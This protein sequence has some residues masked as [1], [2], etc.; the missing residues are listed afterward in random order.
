[1]KKHT[2]RILIICAVIVT[3]LIV[4]AAVILFTMSGKH[5]KVD[6]IKIT[7]S[8]CDVF[9]V[10]AEIVS[11]ILDDEDPL[12][13]I[14]WTN[15][16]PKEYY[17]STHHT[18]Y[19]ESNGTFEKT[20]ITEPS[21]SGTW[22]LHPFEA[23]DDEYSLKYAEL[24]TGAKYR[25]EVKISDKAGKEE[26]KAWIEFE[27][28]GNASRAYF[29]AT[30]IERVY[31]VDNYNSDK[32]YLIVEP[33]DWEPESSSSDRIVVDFDT[34]YRDAIDYYE[35]IEKGTMVRILY[36]GRIE[37]TYPAKL[38]KV[39]EMERVLHLDRAEASCVSLKLYRSE[40]RN[41]DSDSHDPMET[42]YTTHTFCRP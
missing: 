15:R 29:Y 25:I 6:G 41:K 27:I 23:F 17:I 36:D 39:Y 1:M 5:S 40:E 14:K 38:P 26:G 10:S 3:V 18:V 37:E 32:D 31:A 30:V 4:C 16:T 12:L 7:D 42:F 35:L 20:E 24:R 21:Y 34:V 22:A 2:L 8:G 11:A 28:S 9:G 19:I 33:F 13:E